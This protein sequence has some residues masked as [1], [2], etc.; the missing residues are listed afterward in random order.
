MKLLSNLFLTLAATTCMAQAPTTL[1][2]AY[3]NAFKMGTV[4]NRQ[5][6]M[7]R[8]SRSDAIVNLHHKIPQV[9]FF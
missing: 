9:V 3:A 5:M 4:V 7:G 8:D 2:Q 6:A 1:K